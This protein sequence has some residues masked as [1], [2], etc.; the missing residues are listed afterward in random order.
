MGEAS[1][2]RNLVVLLA[3][4]LPIVALFHRLRFPSIV[5]F[6]LAGVVIG[7]NGVGII[8]HSDDVTSL[9]EMGVALLLFVAGLE[10]SFDELVRMRRVL[11][12]SGVLQV[13]VTTALAAGIG[14]L[15]GARP[16]VAV[17][18]GFVVTHSSTAIIMK[19]LGERGELNAPHGRLVSGIALI[20][21]LALVPMVLITRVLADPEAGS[22][23]TV[24]F[25]LAKATVAVAAT[26]LLAVVIVPWVFRQVVALQSREL[27]AGTVVLCALGTAWVADA[28]GLSVALGALAAGLV[29]SESEYSH[30]ALAEILPFRDALNSVFF[31]SVGMLVQMATL[32]EHW[33]ALLGAATGIVVFKAIVAF[34]VALPFARSVRVAV[35]AALTLAEVGEVA[36]VLLQFARPMDLV[37]PTEYEMLVT[38]VALTMVAAPFLIGGAP[39]VANALGALLRAPAFGKPV[40]ESRRGHVVIVGYGLNGENLARVLRETGI[41]FAVLEL[42][43]DRVQAARRG[44]GSVVFG[45]ASRLE[46]LHQA[47]V[48]H[49]SV[50]VVAVSDP[51]ATRR[52]VALSRQSNPGA[53]I[54][55]RTRYQN[56]IDELRR[57][58]ATEVIPEE[59]ETSVEIFAHVLRCLHVP[60]NV[61]ALQ[62]DLI[63]REGYRML[64]GLQLPRQTLD[65][66]HEIL[67]ATTTETFLVTAG[68]PGI[69]QT[70]GGLGLRH[71]TGV[72]IIA[73]VRDGTPIANPPAELEVRQGD[74]V[75]MLGNH[76]QIDRAISC[77]SPREQGPD[78]A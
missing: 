35:A 54:I 5:G 22:F 43:P 45:D 32:R 25:V 6:L 73:V 3:A 48:E 18:G 40:P 49:A 78:S 57:L 15:A 65:Q 28:L 52:I 24:A 64:R 17:F 10:L 14:I 77:L 1:L 42:N 36:F 37:S 23:A 74:I 33:P 4:G 47:G 59:F 70:I 38:V 67:A 16:A 44:G 50:V 19:V 34:A 66:L 75:V 30:Q 8:Q 2:L 31:I 55:V 9:A 62:V 41:R 11:V 39:A 29:L 61:I 26:I 53:P 20:Q 21:D 68:S 58:G 13:V 76:E 60:R 56:E 63:R 7:P 51:A 71:A 46:V 72:T 12:W 27:F 69:G